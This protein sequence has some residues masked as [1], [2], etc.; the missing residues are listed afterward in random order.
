MR[1]REELGS[2]LFM[3]D[4]LAQVEDALAI[5]RGA[6]GEAEFGRL[7]VRARDVS[8]ADAVASVLVPGG[9]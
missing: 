4:E 2:P 9:G 8:V 1:A 6:L 5:A 7:T 3:P